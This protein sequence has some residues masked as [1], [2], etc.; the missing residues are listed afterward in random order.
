MTMEPRDRALFMGIAS[1]LTRALPNGWA[2]VAFRG[3]EDVVTMGDKTPG[4][5]LALMRMAVASLEKQGVE[6]APDVGELTYVAGL[7]GKD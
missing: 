2:L 4:E 1:N 3:P 7:E 5:L 6:A